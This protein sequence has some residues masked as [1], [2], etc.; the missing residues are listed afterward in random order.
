MPGV[1][2]STRATSRYFHPKRPTRLVARNEPVDHPCVIN[3]V[4]TLE[5]L[6]QVRWGSAR[7]KKNPG[8]DSYMKRGRCTFWNLLVTGAL[9][10]HPFT[11]WL[12]YSMKDGW[13]CDSVPPPMESSPDSL[14]LFDIVGVRRT[15]TTGSGT[16]TMSV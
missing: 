5:T 3:Y 11:A 6:S 12:D 13:V 15:R 4:R 2:S 7:S 9:W 1:T 8:A 14:K 10:C 16:G